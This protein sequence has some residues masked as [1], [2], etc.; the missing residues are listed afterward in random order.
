[1]GPI[2]VEIRKIICIPLCTMVLQLCIAE[3]ANL[4]LL[5]GSFSCKWSI[6]S[7]GKTVHKGKTD[8]YQVSMALNAAGRWCRITVSC[9]GNRLTCLVGPDPST[10]RGL[11]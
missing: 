2:Y 6:E 9:G 7:N 4:P 5:S 8:S 11:H 10:R 1:M 3:L